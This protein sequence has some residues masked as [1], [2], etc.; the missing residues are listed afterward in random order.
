MT[1]I[2]P[3]TIIMIVHF[4]GDILQIIERFI[5]G[6]SKNELLCEDALLITCD[7]IAVVDGVTGKTDRKFNGL[8]GGKAAALK[9][10]ECIAVFPADIDCYTAVEKITDA[11]KSLYEENESVGAA[12]AG[13]IIFSKA[14]NEIWNVGDCRCVINGELFS[15]EKEI[16]V[17]LSDV[18]SLVLESEKRKGKTLQELKEND[19][20]REFILPLLKCQHIFA[21]ADGEFSYGVFNGDKIPKDKIIIYKVKDGDEIVLASDGYPYLE[22]TLEESE[23]RLNEEIKNNPLCDGDFRSTKGLVEG[24]KS[25]DD[26]T[27]IRFKV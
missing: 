22:S 15:H 23:K 4:G 8:S 12:A 24:N 14:R 25:F 26:R 1:K 11:V 2:S 3:L 20:G 5:E 18:R 6:K 9:A 17:L 13:A 19:L 10:C 21:N 27:Y 7:F 16:D